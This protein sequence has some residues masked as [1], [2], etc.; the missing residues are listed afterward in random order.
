MYELKRSIITMQ[1]GVSARTM[2]YLKQINK[3]IKMSRFA[4]KYQR[5]K[6]NEE[7]EAFLEIIIVFKMHLQSPHAVNDHVKIIADGLTNLMN[8]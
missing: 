4:V 3:T 6:N 5:I 1:R 7:Q 8:T 2:H